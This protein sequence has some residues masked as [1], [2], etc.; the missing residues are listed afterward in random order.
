VPPPSRA[1]SSSPEFLVGAGIALGASR[2]LE[3]VLRGLGRPFQAGLAEIIALAVTVG[4]LAALVPW[5]GV[6]GA[7]VTSLAAYA[8]SAIVMLALAARALDVRA[9]SLLVPT[10]EDS[11]AI[12]GLTRGILGSRARS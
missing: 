11:S 2:T 3:A 10:R 4:G 1:S 6:K 9:L 5:L 12:L 8:V 7:A